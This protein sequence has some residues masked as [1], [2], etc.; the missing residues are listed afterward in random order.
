MK[1]MGGCNSCGALADDEIPNERYMRLSEYETPRPEL[2]DLLFAWPSDH[3]LK[4]MQPPESETL[5]YE[6]HFEKHMTPPISNER[7]LSPPSLTKRKSNKRVRQGHFILLESDLNQLEV[8]FWPTGEVEILG[9][10]KSILYAW[11]G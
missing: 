5:S 6:E 7:F 10:K 2:H 1:Q 11:E 4:S 8:V 9:R 3:N